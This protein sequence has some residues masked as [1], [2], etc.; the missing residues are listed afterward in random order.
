[1]YALVSS[2]PFDLM[3]GVPYTALPIA[4]LMSSTHDRPMVMR[5]KEGS[6]AYGLKK[7][8]EG[9]FSAGQTCLVV[10]DLVTSGMSVFETVEP[11]TECGLKVTDIVVLIDREQGG[12]KNIESRGLQ[13]HAVVTISQ[14]M[15]ILERHGKITAKVAQEVRDFVRASQ[16]EIKVSRSGTNRREAHETETLATHTTC[17]FFLSCVRLGDR[18]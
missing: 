6:K 14:V 3:C 11:L 10:E 9:V 2:R 18:C 17:D 16:V 7:Q 13:L 8:L 12:R 5:R 1:M 15:E 4:T